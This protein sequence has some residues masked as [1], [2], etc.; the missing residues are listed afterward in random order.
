[1]TNQIISSMNIPLTHG[2]YAIVDEADY[3][4]LNQWKWFVSA[5]GYAARN[6]YIGYK[7]GV[8]NQ[9]IHLMHRVI[10]KTSSGLQVDHINGD[11]LDNRKCNLRNSSHGQNQQNR[12]SNKN[13][14]SKY[15]GVHWSKCARKWIVE[16]MSEREKKYIGCFC[17]EE[18]A[19]LA[20]NEA[21]K[22]YHG[23]FAY[24]NRVK[25]VCS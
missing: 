23:E 7:N 21:A 14:S 3:E 15:K 11:R 24:Q 9:K 19:A 10:M 17:N 13:T 22:K 6:Q 20:Y 8:Q 18:D 5:Q 12:G 2:F 4:W 25:E 16:I 1:M